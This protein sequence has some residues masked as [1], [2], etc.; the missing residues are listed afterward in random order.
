ME[1]ETSFVDVTTTHTLTFVYRMKHLD[2]DPL[3]MA[4]T[5]LMST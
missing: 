3:F 2:F 1:Y 5:A 4:T